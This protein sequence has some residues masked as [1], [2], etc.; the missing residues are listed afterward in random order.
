MDARGIQNCLSDQNAMGVDVYAWHW[1][2]THE[3]TAVLQ[4]IAEGGDKS[5]MRAVAIVHERRFD[6][7][8]KRS[9]INLLKIGINKRLPEAGS[10]EDMTALFYV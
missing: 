3:L 4:L 6:L 9:S 10:C 7:G 5:S 8:S 1:Q 2:I